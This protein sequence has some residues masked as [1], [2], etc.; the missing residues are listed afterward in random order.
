MNVVIYAGKNIS[1]FSKIDSYF[2]SHGFIYKM[3]SGCLCD[4]VELDE[5]AEH[6]LAHPHYMSDDYGCWTRIKEIIERN[7]DTMFYVA[8]VNISERARCYKGMP[9]VV[10]LDCWGDNNEWD[11]INE[12]PISYLQE[13][14]RQS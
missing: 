6:V 13:H 8:A 4:V 7:P 12:D 2:F 1:L 5:G 10:V 9:N 11:K 3:H 14:S